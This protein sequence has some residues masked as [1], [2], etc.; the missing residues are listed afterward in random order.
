MDESR[1]ADVDYAESLRANTIKIRFVGNKMMLDYSRNRDAKIAFTSELT[2]A[3]GVKI[4]EP[5]VLNPNPEPIPN[6]QPRPPVGLEAVDLNEAIRKSGFGSDNRPVHNFAYFGN[7]GL[8]DRFRTAKEY[9]RNADPFEKVEAQ[10]KID[11]IQAEIDEIQAKIAETTFFGTYDFSIPEYSVKIQ[12]D[13]TDCSLIIET[14]INSPHKNDA[15]ILFPIPGV[16]G[17]RTDDGRWMK[18]E[19]TVSGNTNSIQELARNSKNYQAQVRLRNLQGKDWNQFLGSAG[20]PSAEVLEIA[21]V[22]TGR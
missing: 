3:D 19:I 14:N 4:P 22:K 17:T 10:K 5:A 12:G 2:V 18:I 16:T 11:A 1:R 6:P 20:I 21:I 7:A 15:P 9:H 8:R 13:H